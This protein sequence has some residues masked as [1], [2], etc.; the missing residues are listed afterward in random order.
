[1][2]GGVGQRMLAG[3]AKRMAGEFFGNVDAAIGAAGGRRR[4]RR[5]PPTASGAAP[6]VGQVFTA[7][8][9]ARGLVA[10][11]LP[12]GHRRR[13]RAGAARRASPAGASVGRSPATDRAAGRVD[14]DRR[15]VGTGDGRGGR[16]HGDL[17]ARAA[18]PAPGPDRRAQPAS[19]TRSSRST[20]SAPGRARPR[21][22]RRP[23]RGDALGPL[24][25]LPF[26]FKDTHDVAGWRTTYGSPLFAD[27]V[28]DARRPASSSGSARAGAVADREDQRAGVRGRLA[29]LQHGLRHHPQPGRPDPVGRRLERGSGVRAAPR[30]WCRSPTA[31][32]WAAR[33]ATPRRSAASSGCG[34]RSAGCRRGRPTTSGRPLGTSGPLARNV[35]DLALLLSVIAGPDPR[36]PTALGEPGATVRAAAA[37]ATCAGCASRCRADLGGALRGRRAR[38]RAVVER[39]APAFAAGRGARSSRR[40][41]TSPRPTTPSARCAPGCSRPRFGELLAEHPDAFKQSLADNIRAGE[42]LTGADVARAYA[43]AHGAVGADARVLRVVRRAGAADLAGAA[44]PRRPGVP[45]RRS[46]AGRWRPTWTGCAR[47]T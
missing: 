42:T 13:R 32:T 43:A 41:P 30:G 29:H 40:T 5:R 38:S 6:A 45:R 46:T 26:A 19:S 47:R 17:G 33:C 2:V 10:A 9:P 25:G 31:P 21:P 23:A 14:L 22:T 35:D 4:R 44:V 37:A 27:H 16:A 12:Q 8:A 36:V 28:P 3:V 1:M 7:P 11:G 15:V 18:R 20:R 39:P 34:R 24:H